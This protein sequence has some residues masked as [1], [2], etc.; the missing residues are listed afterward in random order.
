MK[1]LLIAFESLNLKLH[2]RLVMAPMTRSKSPKHIPGKDVAAYYRRRIEGGIGLIITE[3][4]VVSHKAGH[5]YPDVPSFYG[6]DSLAGWKHVVDEVHAAGGK[7]FPQL[8]HVGSVRQRHKCHNQ[9]AD[10][11]QK[12]CGFENR[13]PGYAPSAVPHPYVEEA[14][15]PYEMTLSDIKQVI[16][17]FAQAAK[18]AQRL[19]FDGVEIHGAH[20]Y[21]I[22]QFFWEYTNKRDDQYGGKTLAERTR[23]AVELITAV[24]DAVGAHFPID[25]RFSQWKL[26]NYEAKLAKSPQELET[27]LD[28]LVKAGV[29]LFHCS[30]R[31][32]WEPEF[33]DSS[34]NL[35]GWTK[36]ITGLPT[37]TVGSVGLDKDFVSTMTEHQPPHQNKS[38][39]SELLQRFEN[40]E[41]DLIAIGRVLL[42]DP[43]WFQ[44][45]I[46]GREKEIIPF[47]TLALSQLY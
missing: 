45:L 44:K 18:D 46:K 16:D 26:G 30:T 31:R 15:I 14:E 37:I 35:A 41:Y 38:H 42:A 20:G 39:L 24:R 13:I 7:I 36:K 19:G 3:G 17:A 2:N 8:W 6:K 10:N 11:P 34:L 1:R 28:P 23:F 40:N 5:G 29:D 12:K 32:F 9:G 25:F 33:V 21:L 22:D 47:T 43:Y 27:F 4:T